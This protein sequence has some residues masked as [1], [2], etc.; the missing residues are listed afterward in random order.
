M[1]YFNCSALIPSYNRQKWCGVQSHA[2]AQPVLK[3]VAVY[4]IYKLAYNFTLVIHKVFRNDS[5]INTE[6]N[7][8]VCINLSRRKIFVLE[9]EFRRGYEFHLGRGSTSAQLRWLSP[10]Y[11]VGFE[12][13]VI[14]SFY[15]HHKPAI[16]VHDHGL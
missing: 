1:F 12:A 14:T 3:H 6:Q 7:S 13:W 4:S 15:D 11:P 2:N 10:T 8:S 5:T 9:V 16:V